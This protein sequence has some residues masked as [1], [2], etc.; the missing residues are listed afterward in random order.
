MKTEELQFVM[1]YPDGRKITYVRDE[2]PM[3]L[4]KEEKWNERFNYWFGCDWSITEAGKQLSKASKTPIKI[5]GD[6]R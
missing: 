5:E 4:W 1:T 3:Y 2:E 6:S